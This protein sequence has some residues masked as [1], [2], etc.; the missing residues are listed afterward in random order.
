MTYFFTKSQQRKKQNGKILSI[1]KLLRH[2]L[3]S[4]LASCLFILG[5]VNRAK[6]TAMSGMY[7]T[8]IVFH[9]PTKRL[10]N[11]S[12]KWL[13]K[14]GFLFITTDHLL[15]ILNKKSPPPKGAVWISFDDGWRQN[16]FNVLPTIAKHNIPVTFF[17]TVSP[18]KDSGIF[19]WN[20]ADKHRKEVR[21][22]YQ[23]DRNDLFTL[24]EHKRKEIV[25]DLQNRFSRYHSRQ[26]MTIDEVQTITQLPQVTIGNHTLNHPI[27]PNCTIQ[28]IESEIIE[29][30]IFLKEWTNTDVTFFAYP[31]GAF[32]GREI[33]L[34]SKLGFTI[35]TTTDNRLISP[36]DSPYALPR[37]IAMD[38]GFLLENIC[39]MLGIWQP[40]ISKIRKSLST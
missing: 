17:L 8:P 21:K 16:L 26:A 30:N 38:E 9:N 10:F 33:P 12:I 19:W 40:F 27:M 32:D 31:N 25:R 7:V 4:T 29:A 5:Y 15:D 34:L 22:L 28:E 2:F 14:N 23:V 20:L 1:Q 18:V 6:K 35:A 37:F 24:P 3:A 39:H 11:S 36:N 13:R